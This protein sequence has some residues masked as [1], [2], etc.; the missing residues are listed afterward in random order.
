MGH[1]MGVLVV[2]AL[3]ALNVYLVPLAFRSVTGP[4]ENASAPTP[5]EPSATLSDSPAPSPT[6]G[7]PTP[8][9]DSPLLLA[10]AEQTVVRATPGRCGGAAPTLER[11]TDGGTDFADLAL[12]GE[13]K[14]ILALE[15]LSP[16]RIALTALDAD[17]SP[18]RHVS[19][20]R[21]NDWRT[22]SA[23][24]HWSRGGEADQVLSPNGP[25]DVPCDPVDMSTVKDD[26]VRVLCPDGQVLRTYD[27]QTWTTAGVVKGARAIR[28]P[29]PDIGLALARRGGCAAAVLRTV[30]SGATWERLA[31]LEGEPGRAITGQDGRYVAQAGRALHVSTDGGETWVR[32]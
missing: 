6:P 7:E 16:R 12:P 21:G 31:C 3:V 10:S 1:R 28:F 15:A 22:E 24:G 29:V 25:L 17:C 5:Q 18:V 2:V 4:P 26:F 30:D 8:S 14:Q 9:K 23:D 13:A 11:S 32:P 20:N 27:D 19:N